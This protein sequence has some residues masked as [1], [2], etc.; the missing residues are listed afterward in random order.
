MYRVYVVRMLCYSEPANVPLRILAF[1]QLPSKI[2]LKMNQNAYSKVSI[3][4]KV[5]LKSENAE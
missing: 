3:S 5:A 2:S 4:L 1:G